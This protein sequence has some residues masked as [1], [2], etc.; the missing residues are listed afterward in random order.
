MGA[1]GHGRNET[2]TSVVT[3]LISI[4]IISILA[5]LALDRLIPQEPPE[6]GQ[7]PNR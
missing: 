5:Y 1:L 3:A 2:H 4:A 7:P 6:D